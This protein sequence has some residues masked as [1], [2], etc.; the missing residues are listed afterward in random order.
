MGLLL[1]L[2]AGAMIAHAQL[3]LFNVSGSVDTLEGLPPDPSIA[4]GAPFSVQLTYDISTPSHSDI[5][6]TFYLPVSNNITVGN[7]TFGL[8]DYSQLT[9]ARL[10]AI[11][12]YTSFG[13]DRE[14]AL[15]GAIYMFSSHLELFSH[16]LPLPAVPVAAFDDQADLTAAGP[17]WQAKGQITSFMIK[18]LQSP[19]AVPESSSYGVVG[20]AVLAGLILYRRS[21]QRPR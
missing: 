10:Y 17:G 5:I 8:V 9:P 15:S 13:F 14:T 12:G 16:Q 18:P 7:F 1:S 6:G 19:G 11:N 21:G 2:S 3:F 20:A 4:L